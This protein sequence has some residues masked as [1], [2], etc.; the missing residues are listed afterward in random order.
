MAFTDNAFFQED[1]AFIAAAM[2]SLF[3][4]YEQL[5]AT[6]IHR[7]VTLIDLLKFR[8][9]CVFLQA[10]L[11][12]YCKRRKL[13][14]SPLYY[15]SLVAHFDKG[16]VLEWI[17]KLTGIR[18]PKGLL[19]LLCAT[20]EKAAVFDLQY[21]PI[22]KIA[23]Q[24]LIPIGVVAN[25][26]VMRN[27]LQWSR[28]R[29]DSGAKMDPLGDRLVT[30]F[31]EVGMPAKAKIGVRYAD[32][33]VEADVLAVVDNHLFAFECKNSLHPC[34]P[35]ELR[36]SYNYIV[37]AAA[38][39]DRFRTFLAGE[40]FRR[41]LSNVAGFDITR[42]VGLT[43]CIVTGNRMFNGYREGGHAVWTVYE[44]TNVVTG[45]AL[46]LL[47]FP[48]DPTEP[49]G[50]EIG[51]RVNSWGGE[52]I[53]ASDLVNYIERGSWHAPAF[54]AIDLHDE[55][56]AFGQRTLRFR[57]FMFDVGRYRDLMRHHPQA[58]EMEHSK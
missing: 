31:R 34:N 52:R 28:F 3:V 33:D 45:G 51:V 11:D 6:P 38:Q 17:S 1:A 13:L 53:S 36:Q 49:N 39:L 32:T 26:N 41:V 43:T 12:E 22:M 2:K 4:T 25:C 14:T 37:K 50:P 29:F 21:T 48:E 46:V 18:E 57:S 47:P 30:A 44:L 54:S 35:Y 8:R 16:Q 55:I 23:G 9:L 5:L 56:I 27:A 7:G 10:A 58:V 40:G 15:R 24:Y 42:C 19:E 20:D